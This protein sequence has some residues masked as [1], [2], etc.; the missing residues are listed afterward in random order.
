MN[1]VFG[2]VKTGFMAN[3]G[4]AS[5]FIIS[6][7][8]NDEGNEGILSVVIF[9]KAS[10]KRFLNPAEGVF[11]QIFTKLMHFFRSVFQCSQNFL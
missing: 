10:D 8:C 11:S 1:D 9:G 4:K 5:M 3:E 6:L 2:L 7:S